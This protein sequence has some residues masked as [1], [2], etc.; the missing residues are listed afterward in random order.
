MSFDL[1]FSHGVFRH[2]KSDKICKYISVHH[3]GKCTCHG[4][5]RFIHVTYPLYV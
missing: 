3:T 2:S 1:G 5:Y 4:L